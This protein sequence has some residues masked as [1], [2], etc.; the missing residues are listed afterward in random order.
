MDNYRRRSQKNE[1]KQINDMVY[2]PSQ[3]IGTVFN[4]IQ[5]YQDLCALLQNP[6]SDMQL[7][8]YAYLL[9]HKNGNIYDQLKR[10]EFKSS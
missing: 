8:T 1:I 10:L 5:E 3:G 2:N 6:K 7:V 9:F 4:K